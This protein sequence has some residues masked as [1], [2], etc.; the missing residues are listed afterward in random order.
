M[1]VDVPA[2]N[3]T[4]SREELCLCYKSFPWS[5]PCPTSG[6]KCGHAGIPSAQCPTQWEHTKN[7]KKNSPKPL[8]S[9]AGLE[10]IWISPQ[11][12]PTKSPSLP[13]SRDWKGSPLPRWPEAP[14]APEAP[15]VPGKGCGWGYGLDLWSCDAR[16]W[17]KTGE[18]RLENGSKWNNIWIVHDSSWK[19]W[20]KYIDVLGGDHFLGNLHMMKYITSTLLV[21]FVLHP[22]WRI[23]W[24]L[25]GRPGVASNQS[26]HKRYC[27][28]GKHHGNMMIAN[29]FDNTNEIKRA[30]THQNA[31]RGDFPYLTRAPNSDVHTWSVR[32]Y[33]RLGSS[34]YIRRGSKKMVPWKYTHFHYASLDL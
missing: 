7:T 11:K 24:F 21:C 6:S 18:S 17:V 19:I 25:H 12:G 5:L 4:L 15:E 26:C 1:D 33:T 30:I 32:L 13:W 22:S 28:L 3:S 29:Y 20:L 10:G 8:P 23:L 2:N 34:K 9:M 27:R 14:E 16:A 31:V